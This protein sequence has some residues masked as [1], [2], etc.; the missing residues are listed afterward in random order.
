M[1]NTTLI[2]KKNKT[3]LIKKLKSV[4]IE[5]FF[6]DKEK[7]IHFASQDLVT[8]LI[9]AL[10]KNFE[11]LQTDDKNIPIPD[12]SFIFFGNDGRF[13]NNCLNLSGSMILLKECKRLFLEVVQ[14]N[15][16]EIDSPYKILHIINTHFD[17]TENNLIKEARELR[18]KDKCDEKCRQ[19]VE[20]IK[21][22][23]IVYSIKPDGEIIFIS[24]S[25]QSVLGLEPEEVIG[26]NIKELF[27][28][29]GV[30]KKD[31]NE[32]S[33]KPSGSGETI[34]F[35]LKSDKNNFNKSFIFRSK[36]WTNYDNFGNFVS[37]D[38][39][40][41]DITEQ[42]NSEIALRKSEHK[43][44]TLLDNL[45]QRVF[46]K[47]K[48]SVY[49]M[50]NPSYA[51]DFN[52]LPE[53]F[54]G[55]TD[56]DFHPADLA[57]K[58]REDDKKILND[59][60]T[61]EF[62][63]SYVLDGKTR[64]VHT[65]KVPVKNEAGKVKGL[66]GIFWDITKNKELE[67]KLKQ[68]EHELLTLSARLQL[69]VKSARI[70]I[71]DFNITTSNVV[72]D[73]R[74]YE[75]YEIDKNAGKTSYDVWQ[76]SVHPDDLVRTTNEMKQAIKGEK[77]FDTE[78]RIITSSGKLKYIK[79]F[80]SVL[81]NKDNQ[82]ERLIGINYD[83]TQKT[84]DEFALKKYADMQGVLL[85]EVNHRVKNNLA[86]LIS[87]L[88][89]EEDKAI[90]DNKN[91]FVPMLKDLQT[92]II[93]LSTVHSL[94]SSANWQPLNLTTLCKQ[95]ISGVMN[96][97]H[98]SQRPQFEVNYSDLKVNID[99]AHHLALVVNEL[100]SNTLKHFHSKAEAIQID[101][102]IYSE[103]DYIFIQYKDNGKGYPS[104]MISGDMRNAN[105]GF[106][107]IKGI[108]EQSLNGKVTISNDEGAVTLLKFEN[109]HSE[110]G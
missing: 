31:F 85:K 29:E 51:S 78:F 72:W 11:S 30:T 110:K 49:I 41:H 95:I 77:E 27:T 50:V 84:E 65:V 36:L 97:Y 19:L 86:A 93:G 63:E 108:V 94:L 5:G 101:V 53:D 9:T 89:K 38:G 10:E 39:I 92:R 79:A 66:L 99:Q 107:L 32:L 83:I 1:T 37:L 87:I 46:Y 109:E 8:N 90:A 74:I 61:I 70:G 14:K 18:N 88:H 15:I 13:K 91:H 42:R 24:S 100:A 58:Y 3:D 44:K 35:I 26:K 96:C 62:D 68:S 106:D 47:D 104:K 54:I 12:F 75:L 64:T 17:V 6:P 60:V 103:K 45:P 34:I 20:G 43:Y 57:E 71:W 59:K 2:F 23:F 76:K 52:L 22:E 105:I 82:P 4:D 21:D 28:P 98:Y 16:N 80:G 73:D 56:Y 81:K 67:E 102:N 40:A 48:N 33:K 69:A 25:V 7:F 55:K